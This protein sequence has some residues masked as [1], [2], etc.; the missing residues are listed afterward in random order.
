MADTHR[1]P[2]LKQ[3]NL[4]PLKNGALVMELAKLIRHTAWPIE[5]NGQRWLQHGL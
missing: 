3:H 2:L 5:R 1:E 4:L